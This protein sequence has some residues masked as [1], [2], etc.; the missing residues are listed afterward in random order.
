MQ[1]DYFSK[2]NEKGFDRPNEDFIFIKEN[3]FILCDGVSRDRTNGI[4]ET[5]SKAR[6]VSELFANSV[7]EFSKEKDFD[8]NFLKDAFIYGN[9][10]IKKYNDINYHGNFLPGTVCVAVILVN[11]KLFFSYIGDCLGIIKD[12]EIITFTSCQTLKI[13]EYSSIINKDIIRNDICNNISHPL[14][15][16][17]LDGRIGAV[18]FIKRGKIDIENKDFTVILGSDGIE[19]IINNL[20]YKDFDTISAKNLVNRK[21]SSIDDK[22]VIIIRS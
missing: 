16:G 12:K 21:T 17:V 18:P 1:I 5:P 6:I 4:Y 15:Y 13:R 14:S 22:S 11:N 9:Q 2:K 10:K 20:D 19:E 3:L 8:E 7:Y